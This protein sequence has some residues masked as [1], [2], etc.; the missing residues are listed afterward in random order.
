[1]LKMG[2]WGAYDITPRSGAFYSVIWLCDNERE[3]IAQPN[4]AVKGPMERIVRANIAHNK[5]FLDYHVLNK[6]QLLIL[7]EIYSFFMASDTL[8]NL[9]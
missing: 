9:H 4:D 6:R 3:R 5:M 2:R 1:M 8:Y 7:V